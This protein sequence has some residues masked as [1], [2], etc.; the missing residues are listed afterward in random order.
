MPPAEADSVRYS[1]LAIVAHGGAGKSTLS[2]Y[3]YNDNRVKDHFDVRMWICISRKLDVHRHTR[4]IIEF[5]TMGSVLMLIILILSSAN[6]GTC[7]KSQRDS[8]LS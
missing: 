6:Y 3:V 4:E 8:C 2:Q 1:G 5:A 7:F